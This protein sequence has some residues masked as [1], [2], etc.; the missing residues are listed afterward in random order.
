M[1]GAKL[2]ASGTVVKSAAAALAVS[3]AV[4]GAAGVEVA[5]H[6]ASHPVPAAKHARTGER[7][8]IVSPTGDPARRAASDRDPAATGIHPRAPGVQ[9]APT[10]AG[11]GRRLGTRK[12]HGSPLGGRHD[13]TR[14]HRPVL[15]P[16]RRA[17]QRGSA[18]GRGHFERPGTASPDRTRLAPERSPDGTRNRGSDEKTRER[19]AE[20][21]LPAG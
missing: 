9:G 4:G 2:W 8:H 1:L 3:A 20:S 18:N 6:R 5:R 17:S 11:A 7:P 19:D 13:V 15:R 14:E 21:S 10:G 16:D 12:A